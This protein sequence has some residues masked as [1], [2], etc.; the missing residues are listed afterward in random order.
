MPLTTLDHYSI[1][2][3]KLEETREFYEQLGMHTGDRPDF[4]FP[5]HWLYVGEKAIVHLVGI[6]EDNPE[7][8]YEY[9]GESVDFEEGGGA[10]DH[11]AFNA[12]DRAGLKAKL[13]D[14]GV[15]FKERK[16]PNMELHQIFVDDPNEI[17]V[18]INYWED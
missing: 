9:L 14:L 17:T 2:T 16:V 3:L 10:L 6:D 4:P 13:T 15:P 11:V 5:G 8:L 18:E 7:G 12:T 1:R